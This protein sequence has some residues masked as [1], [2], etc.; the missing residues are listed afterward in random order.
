MLRGLDGADGGS[1][2]AFLGVPYA[3]PATGAARFAAPGPADPWVGERDATGFGPTAPMPDRRRFG[4]LDMEPVVHRWVPGDDYRT[5]N[6]WTPSTSGKAPVLVFV[7]GG[8]F[9]AGSGAASAYHGAPFA[10]AGVVLVT[11][12]YR[13]GVPGWLSLPGAPENRGLLDV[14]AALRW[15]RDNIAAFG[16]DPD[17]VT[18]CGQSAGGM[19]V[20]ALLTEPAAD[21]LFRRAISQSGGLHGLEPDRAAAVGRQLAGVLDVPATVEAFAEVPDERLV[22][23]LP[24]LVPGALGGLAPLAVVLEGAEVHGGVE[25]L[26]GNTSQEAR[27]YQDPE[28]EEAIDELFRSASERLV[29]AHAAAGGRA[30]RYLF[31]WRDGPYGACHA[32]ELPFVFGTTGLPALR[33]PGGLLGPDVPETLGEEVHGAWVR[34]ATSGDPGWTGEHRFT[35]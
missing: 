31:D 2:S 23:C 7:H 16:G 22:A 8:A 4:G 15:V 30:H 13:L 35:G 20:G 19:I 9:L 18:V 3:A 14:L 33:S 29:S 34:F 21:G 17:Q 28:R 27:L 11:C 5:V 6:V 1:G 24:A 32:V 26:V 12:N 10:R 25:L